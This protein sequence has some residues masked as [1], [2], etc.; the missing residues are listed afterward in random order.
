MTQSD[1]A[2]ILVSFDAE[3]GIDLW[4]VTIASGRHLDDGML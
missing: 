2:F 3:L 1:S 4:L